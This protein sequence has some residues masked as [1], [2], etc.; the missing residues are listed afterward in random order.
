[1][2]PHSKSLAAKA[3]K[4]GLR[5]GLVLNRINQGWSVQK[6]LNTPVREYNK[7]TKKKV[8]KKKVAKKISSKV[9]N[10]QPLPVEYYKSEKDYVEPAKVAFFSI[11]GA[12]GIIILAILLDM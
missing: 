4:K 10:P 5:P 7:K 2:T 9:S 8:A 3:R 6:A 11:L 12:V 1:M